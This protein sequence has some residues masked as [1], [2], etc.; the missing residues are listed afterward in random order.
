MIKWRYVL[1]QLD[2]CSNSKK[3]IRSILEFKRATYS[4]V[5]M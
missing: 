4:S 5:N 3:T 2:Y 1:H